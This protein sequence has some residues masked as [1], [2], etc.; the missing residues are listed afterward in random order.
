MET[1]QCKKCKGTGRARREDCHTC[2]GSGVVA[3]STDSDGN[4]TIKPAVRS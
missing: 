3:I 2:K 1:I 4:K